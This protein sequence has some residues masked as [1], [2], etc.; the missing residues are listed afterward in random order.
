MRIT[1]ALQVVLADAAVLSHVVVATAVQKVTAI[2]ITCFT[3]GCAAARRVVLITFAVDV[4]F[5]D[6]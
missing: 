3:V 2:T 1:G 6:S 5:A 4:I